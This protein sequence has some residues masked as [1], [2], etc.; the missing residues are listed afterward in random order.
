VVETLAGEEALT[1]IDELAVKYT[2][3]PFPM[4]EGTVFLIDAERAGSLK[5][6]FT[7]A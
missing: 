7:P 1:V 5:L 6:P 4:R 2:G 3:Q